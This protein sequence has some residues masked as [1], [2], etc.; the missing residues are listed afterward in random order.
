MQDNPK[1]DR[2]LQTRLRENGYTC[3]SLWTIP[4][5]ENTEVAWMTGYHVNA[6]GKSV[7]V[8]VQTFTN[9]DWQ[10]FIGTDYITD[11]NTSVQ[12]VIDALSR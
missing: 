11:T 10:L 8:I 1:P 2:T 12:A 9:G 7:I 3:L 6:A 4:G 5:P